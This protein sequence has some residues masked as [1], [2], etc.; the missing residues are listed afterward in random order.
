MPVNPASKTCVQ[1]EMS[2]W[3]EGKLHSGSGHLVPPGE[4]GKKQALAISL[5]ACKKSSFSERLANIGFSQESLKMAEEMLVE[6]PDWDK[7]FNTGKTGAKVVRENK[8]TIAVGMP[9][10]DIDNRPGKQKGD[11]GKQRKQ[12]SSTLSAVAI[13]K[14]NPQ[15]GPR[16]RSDLVGLRMFEEKPENC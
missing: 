16:S 15:Q 8:T 4:K 12:D 11:Q 9:D 5:N 6:L 13:P 7:Q 3:Q 14:G 2:L 10:M 1:D